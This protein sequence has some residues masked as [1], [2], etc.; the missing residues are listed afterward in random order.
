[1]RDQIKIIKRN[2]E[3]NHINE[4]QFVN[5]TFSQLN[6]LQDQKAEVEN[7]I[8]LTKEEK[9]FL[10]FYSGHSDFQANSNKC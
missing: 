6:K 7:I 4:N 9:N 10:N 1:M 5:Q 8:Q 3:L 2:F